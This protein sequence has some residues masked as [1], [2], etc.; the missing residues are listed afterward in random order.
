VTACAGT[1]ALIYVVNGALPYRETSVVVSPL[2]NL[3]L[4][5]K[6]NVI[7]RLGRYIVV[8]MCCVVVVRAVSASHFFERSVALSTRT[9]P[10]T[11]YTRREE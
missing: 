10:F 6:V 4:T 5:H 1:G 2:V 11:T 7:R 9:L 8:R 3:S